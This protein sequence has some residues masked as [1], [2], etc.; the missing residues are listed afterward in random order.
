[1]KETLRSFIA[2][3]FDSQA[4]DFLDHL[5][6]EWKKRYPHAKW[7][8]REQF[9]ITLFFFSALPVQNVDQIGTILKETTSRFIPFPVTFEEVGT[10]PSWNRARVLWLGLDRKG[11]QY[12]QQIHVF[13]AQGLK[14]ANI[15]WEEEKRS[16]IPHL[17]LVRFHPPVALSA[18]QWKLETVLPSCMQ[19]MVLFQSTLTP[20]G[21]IYQELFS[22]NLEGVDRS[23][24]REESSE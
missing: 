9:H 8:K 15:A 23:E 5:L 22:C 10:F 6:A 19:R 20:R 14:R 1:M 16:F 11:E 18:S 13:L 12:A 24:R 2:L 17:T 4:K 3:D 21:P 7:V